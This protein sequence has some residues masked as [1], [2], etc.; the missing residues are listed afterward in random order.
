MLSIKPKGVQKSIFLNEYRTAVRKMNN[1]LKK[2][3]NHKRHKVKQWNLIYEYSILIGE[4]IENPTNQKCYEWLYHK[5]KEQKIDS[6]KKT[7]GSF[8]STKEWKLLREKVFDLFGY[9]CMKCGSE[10][11]LCVDHIKPRSLFPEFELDINNMQILCNSCNI[12][13]SNR[14][15]TDYRTLI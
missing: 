11:F 4:K 3:G 8:Y 14:S 9:K 7:D 12:S 6:L 13:K 2:N 1:F 10:D 15:F 5:Y